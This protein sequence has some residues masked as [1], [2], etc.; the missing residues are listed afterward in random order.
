MRNIYAIRHAA[1]HNNTIRKNLRRE[2][3]DIR[4][5]G[6]QRQPSGLPPQKKSGKLRQTCQRLKKKICFP[7]TS[8]KQ[9][10]LA[11][12]VL[13]KILYPITREISMLQDYSILWY[14]IIFI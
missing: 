12:D 6:K 9:I 10:L 2:H 13:D 14:N 11:I 1:F 8:E 5:I 3:C 7:K 4:S